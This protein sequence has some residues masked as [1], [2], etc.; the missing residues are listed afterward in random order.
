M[1]DA[2]KIDAAEELRLIRRARR[3]DR[4]ALDRLVAA[5]RPFVRMQAAKFLGRVRYIE[6]DDLEQIGLIKLIESLRSYNVKSGYRLLTY[7]GRGLL[8]AMHQAVLQQRPIRLP[9]CATENES[10]RAKAELMFQVNSLNEPAADGT[11]EGYTRLPDDCPDPGEDAAEREASTALQED[12]IAAIGQLPA[13]MQDIIRA[14][15]AGDT[16]EVVGRRL[17]VTRERIRQIVDR[18]KELMAQYLKRRY[19]GKAAALTQRRREMEVA[20]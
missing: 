4:A 9:S 13:R 6:L 12:V 10:T 3:G 1:K 17:G 14:R 8:Q 18:A 7:V 20:R 2:V 19:A 5:H 11:R 15:M 16:L